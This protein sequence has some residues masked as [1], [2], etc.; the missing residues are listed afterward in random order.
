MEVWQASGG[1]NSWLELPDVTVTNGQWVRVTIHADYTGITNNFNLWIDSTA[2]TNPATYFTSADQDKT[3]F[4]SVELRGNFNLDDLA[5]DDYD[6]LNYRKVT[7]ASHGAGN[8]SP[9]GETL[10]PIGNSPIFAITASNY[11]HASSVELDNATV[12]TG[13]VSQ[14]NYGL[15]NVI[16]RHWL[17]G[18]FSETLATNA[19]P[20]W[21]LAQMNPAWTNNF[22]NHALEDFDN[23][24]MPTWAEY[25]A[26]THPTNS[27]DVLRLK[28]QPLI[29]NG[30]HAIELSWDT[31]IGRE[32]ALY[33]TTN[34]ATAPWQTIYQTN[35]GI[36]TMQYIETGNTN[37]FYKVG[38]Q[39]Q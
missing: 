5:V 32:Y 1:S 8:I 36:G 12:W 21:W 13:A 20:Q 39:I 2:V 10:V 18:W 37:Q 22:D 38:V 6:I 35:T 27:E 4:E 19:T 28:V 29:T 24:L 31:E 14:L 26:G 16:T 25:V 9:A 34:L 23:D 30:I 33:A 11:Y 15:S 17:D 7:A 3:G